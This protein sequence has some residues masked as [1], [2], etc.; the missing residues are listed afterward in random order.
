MKFVKRKVIMMLNARKMLLAALTVLL[1]GGFASF[2]QAAPASK[3]GGEIISIQDDTGKPAKAP[4]A[5]LGNN[6]PVV[7]KD[8]ICP[9]DPKD[10]LEANVAYF[11]LYDAYN[12]TTK[13]HHN[14]PEKG[15]EWSNMIVRVNDKEVA[16]DLLVKLGSKGWH[17][18]K[19]DPKLLKKGKNTVKISLDG[20]KGYLYLAIDS[21]K[22]VGRSSSSNNRGRTFTYKVLNPGRKKE[23]KGEYMIRLKLKVKKKTS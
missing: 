2:V 8:L 23:S 13:R 10:I 19:I 14:K 22:A 21:N 6:Y 4:R 1:F 11:V 5:Q 9:V 16:K 12:K 15:V 17:Q 20:A 18:L 3:D 7:C